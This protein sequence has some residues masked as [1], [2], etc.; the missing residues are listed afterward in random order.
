MVPSTC[1]KLGAHRSI[2][3]NPT[4]N[5]RRIKKLLLRKRCGAFYEIQRL[6]NEIKPRRRIRTEEHYHLERQLTAGRLR[7]AVRQVKAELA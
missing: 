5:I 2:H 1:A 7:P 4:D 6:T 3:V